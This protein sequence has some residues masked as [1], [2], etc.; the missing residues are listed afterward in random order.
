MS[1]DI[2]PEKDTQ[3]DPLFHNNINDENQGHPP[4]DPHPL[5]DDD[6]DT[7]GEEG[8][9]LEEEDSMTLSDLSFIKSVA[10]I[11]PSQLSDI[12]TDER[13]RCYASY[14]ER[15][16]HGP[17][18]EEGEDQHLLLPIDEDNGA[19]QFSP[20]ISTCL[21]SPFTPQSL[22]PPV[23]VEVLEVIQA[24]PSDSPLQYSPAT[25]T[26][27]T[28][29]PPVSMDENH[30]NIEGDMTVDH[31]TA[32]CSTQKTVSKAVLT[33]MK[34]VLKVRKAAL[35]SPDGSVNESEALSQD[36]DHESATS[37]MMIGEIHSTINSTPCEGERESQ[38]EG[39]S[40]NDSSALLKSEL[41]MLLDEEE[42]IMKETCSSSEIL[43][44]SI[45]SVPNDESIVSVSST[46]S[47]I[48]M[49]HILLMIFI[50]AFI[51]IGKLGNPLG[52]SET[53][54]FPAVGPSIAEVKATSMVLPFD[55]TPPMQEPNDHFVE[56]EANVMQK[57]PLISER[58][59]VESTVSIPET[60]EVA[61]IKIE[62]APVILSSSSSKE[63]NKVDVAGSESEMAVARQLYLLSQLTWPLSGETMPLAGQLIAG[64]HYTNSLRMQVTNMAKKILGIL[65]QYLLN[66]PKHLLEEQHSDNLVDLMS[67]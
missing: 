38:C 34:S 54:Q 6:L 65:Q 36:V 19:E 24:S 49:Y 9:D 67:F 30:G 52:S 7:E 61:V 12:S 18:G 8:E 64:R 4:H 43:A 51:V 47:T 23:T 3:S 42:L 27:T 15:H 40:N 21:T 56:N 62:E 44:E 57:F 5:C 31:I 58:E 45:L 50:A 53:T 2:I 14:Y 17:S 22:A 37:A 20:M 26:S 11:S 63:S 10:S 35:F 66:I 29:A 1:T 48:S 25:P 28:A 60:M 55:K 59:S 33:P 39:D 41:M 13:V 16:G 46:G 32:M